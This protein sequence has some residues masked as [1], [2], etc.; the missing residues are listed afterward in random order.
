MLS[1]AVGVAALAG[2]ALVLALGTLGTSAAIPFAIVALA[3]SVYH[4]RR[5]LTFAG[6]HPPH[7]A[8]HA[9]PR[10]FARHAR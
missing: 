10:L 2:A 8:R 3:S 1:G 9:S 5:A 7:F 4:V 6:V